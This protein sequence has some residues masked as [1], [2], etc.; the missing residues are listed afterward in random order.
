M[1]ELNPLLLILLLTPLQQTFHNLTHLFLLFSIKLEFVL[2]L[3]GL[4]FAFLGRFFFIFFFLIQ[5][6]VS[7]VM[8]S[9][10]VVLQMRDDLS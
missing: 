10:I 9:Y 2:I 4:T 1:F 8:L 3:F 5:L 7:E 6:E